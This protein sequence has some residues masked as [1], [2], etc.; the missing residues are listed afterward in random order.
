MFMGKE[1]AS[2]GLVARGAKFLCQCDVCTE[3]KCISLTLKIKE[4]RLSHAKHKFLS[5]DIKQ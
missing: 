2:S 5:S 4:G 3:Y 1:V